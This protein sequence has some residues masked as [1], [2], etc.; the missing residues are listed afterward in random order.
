ME[1][2]INLNNDRLTCINVLKHRES[3]IAHKEKAN[4]L[5]VILDQ[6]NDGIIP[7]ELYKEYLSLRTSL[8]SIGMKLNH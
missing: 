4:K 5:L 8:K 2:K 3:A 6:A 7:K 1:I